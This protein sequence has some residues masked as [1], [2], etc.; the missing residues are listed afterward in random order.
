[1]SSVESK[2]MRMTAVSRH[3]GKIFVVHFKHSNVKRAYTRMLSPVSQI[4][5]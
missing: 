3:L 2:G 5:W 4:T 1:M